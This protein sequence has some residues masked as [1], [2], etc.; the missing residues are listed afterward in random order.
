MSY[1]EWEI[2]CDWRYMLKHP[3]CL[4]HE[5]GPGP[6]FGPLILWL[7]VAVC[8]AAAIKVTVKFMKGRNK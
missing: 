8:V 3:E 7:Y 5:Q 2:M 6:D 4:L 1:L